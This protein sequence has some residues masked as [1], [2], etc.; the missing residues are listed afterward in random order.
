MQPVVTA[1]RIEQTLLDTVHLLHSDAMPRGDLPRPTCFA[2]FVEEILH[3]VGWQA[4]LCS[5]LREHTADNSL[6]ARLPART[7]ER[8]FGGWVLLQLW[9]LDTFAVVALDQESC[10]PKPAEVLDRP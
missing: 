4:E 10:A 5:K 2:T 7:V 1:D 8:S 3:G 9:P 6:C